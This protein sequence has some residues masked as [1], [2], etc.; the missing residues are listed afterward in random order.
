MT[1]LYRIEHDTRYAYAS[2]VSMSQHV[3]YLRPREQPRQH[4]R[5]SALIIEPA[6]ARILHR[7]DYFGNDVAQFQLLHPHSGLR[8]CSRSLVEVYV[9]YLRRKLGT[10][11]IETVRGQGYRLRAPGYEAEP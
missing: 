1:V 4:V 8:V 3:A 9:F 6:P 7:Q 11:L 10:E 5:E 2:T